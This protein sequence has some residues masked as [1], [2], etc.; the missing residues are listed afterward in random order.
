MTFHWV[1]ACVNIPYTNNISGFDHCMSRCAN[2][3]PAARAEPFTGVMLP[4]RASVHNTTSSLLIPR[5]QY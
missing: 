2:A 1:M 3:L 4:S 5:F